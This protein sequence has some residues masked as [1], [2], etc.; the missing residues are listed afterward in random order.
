[1]APQPTAT[2]EYEENAVRPRVAG[3]VTT[4]PIPEH[5][6]RGSWVR[7]RVKVLLR[8]HTIYFCQY[9]IAY[10]RGPMCVEGE[11][12]WKL[13]DKIDRDWLGGYRDLVPMSMQ[14]ASD[15]TTSVQ[16]A[17]SEDHLIYSLSPEVQHVLSQQTMRSGVLLLFLP[18]MNSR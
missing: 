14:P 3:M 11:F 2:G 10:H 6:W 4:R 5:N 9:L 12:I 1:M 16:S 15:S 18:Y 17:S 8:A 7:F 13:K